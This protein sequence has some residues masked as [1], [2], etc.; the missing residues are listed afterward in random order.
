MLPLLL[1]PAA[2]LAV[3]RVPQQLRPIRR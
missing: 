1:L 3:R 2:G